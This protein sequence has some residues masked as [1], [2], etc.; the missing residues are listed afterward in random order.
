MI[1]DLRD[2][3]PSELDGTERRVADAVVLKYAADLMIEKPQVE[4]GFGE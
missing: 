3:I 2:E 1:I 4:R